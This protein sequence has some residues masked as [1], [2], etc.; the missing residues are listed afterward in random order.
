MRPTSILI[1]AS[2]LLV[3]CAPAAEDEAPQETSETPD[4]S[5]TE[6]ASPTPP[7]SLSGTAWRADA[8]DGARFVTYLDEDGSYR[9]L[10]NGDPYQ[11]GEWTYAE[12]ARGKMLCFLPD[13]EAGI[14]TCWEPGKREDDTM[15][16]TGPEGRRV[17]LTSV[18]YEPPAEDAEAE[19][20]A[21]EQ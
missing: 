4:G 8:E 16:V 17:E 1:L 13:D 10:R 9:D 21:G 6:T 2:L 15:I 12:G 18:A 20:E 11:Q 19:E 3:G 5:G 7:D 14:E